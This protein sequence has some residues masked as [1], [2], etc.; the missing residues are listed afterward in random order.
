MDDDAAVLSVK[1]T[2]GKQSLRDLRKQ[3]DVAISEG[4]S[5][6]EEQWFKNSEIE[7]VTIPASVTEI[8]KEAFSDCRNLRRVTFAAGSQLKMIGEQSF[9]SCR[10]EEIVIPRSVTRIGKQAFSGCQELMQVSF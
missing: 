8:G 1:T 7:S 2:V 9:S 5:N 6:I 3:K 4:V 10:V